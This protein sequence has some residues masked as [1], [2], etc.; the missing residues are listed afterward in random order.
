MQ[1]QRVLQVVWSPDKMPCS[2]LHTNILGNMLS[3]LSHLVRKNVHSVLDLCHDGIVPTNQL[4]LDECLTFV[5][6]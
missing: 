3:S 2:Y 5:A 6:R 4:L 1:L